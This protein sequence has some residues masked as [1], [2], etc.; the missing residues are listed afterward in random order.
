MLLLVML[1]LAINVWMYTR[2]QIRTRLTRRSVGV[3]SEQARTI[4][5]H[6]LQLNEL[7]EEG[8]VH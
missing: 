2:A 1:M 8:K 7:K 5:S 6:A 4:Y 3:A